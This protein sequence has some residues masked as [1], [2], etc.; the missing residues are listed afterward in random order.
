M[1]EVHERWERSHRHLQRLTGV[2][3]LVAA[4]LWTVS[5]FAATVAG[6]GTGASFVEGWFGFASLATFAGA[7]GT[8]VGVG[9]GVSAL[10]TDDAPLPGSNY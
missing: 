8:T 5:Y 2:G 7:I 4:S 1:S 3:A 6:W 9:I 10:L